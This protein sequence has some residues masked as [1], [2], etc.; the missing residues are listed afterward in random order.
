MKTAI[1]IINIIFLLILIPSVMSAIMSPMMFDSPGS[2]KSSKT[3]ILFSCMIVLPILIVIAQ[4]ISWIAFFKKNYVLA[5]TIN[6]LPTIDI[7]LIGLIFFIIGSFT[8]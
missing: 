7:L 1:I 2:E 5:I 6:A 3:W 4:I 8:E